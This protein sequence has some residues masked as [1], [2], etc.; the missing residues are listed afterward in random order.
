MTSRR[1]ILLPLSILAATIQAGIDLA[2][3]GDVVLVD[4]G[5]WW[6]ALHV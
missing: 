4:G 2:L 6:R 1:R 3:D 5:T